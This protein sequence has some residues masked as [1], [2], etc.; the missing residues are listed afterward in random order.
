MVEKQVERKVANKK[1]RG[2]IAQGRA[3]KA[4][5][6]RAL[7]WALGLKEK[8]NQVVVDAL[9]MRQRGV[10]RQKGGKLIRMRDMTDLHIQNTIAMLQRKLDRDYQDLLPSAPSIDDALAAH[11]FSRF[12]GR[13]ALVWDDLRAEAGRRGLKTAADRQSERRS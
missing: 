2:Y 6:R 13:M 1:P 9:S 5:L 4:A 8:G 11:A 10:W 3:A 12:E 7:F